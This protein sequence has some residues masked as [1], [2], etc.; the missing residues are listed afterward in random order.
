MFS[1]IK[2]KADLSRETG[3]QYPTLKQA[4]RAAYHLNSKD[5]GNIGRL[6]QYVPRYHVETPKGETVYL[7]RRGVKL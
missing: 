2:I 5:P 1:V 7:G 4:K 3:K 6:G